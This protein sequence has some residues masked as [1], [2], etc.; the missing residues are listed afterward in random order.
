VSEDLVKRAVTYL[1]T[2]FVSGTEAGTLIAEMSDEVLQ[3]RAQLASARKALEECEEVF[4]LVEHPKSVDP[5]YGDRVRRL[6][7]EIG[8][9]A[10]MSSASA[11]WR[12][13]LASKSFAG[14]EFVAGPCQATVTNVLAQVRAALTDE[15]GKS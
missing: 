14:A 7:D 10:L 2:Y 4:S 8:Y 9:G 12:R 3:L 11:S 13:Y 5:A 15:N 6:G 1:A